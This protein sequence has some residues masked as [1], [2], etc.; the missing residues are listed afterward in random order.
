MDMILTRKISNKYGIF[1]ILTDLNQD[2]AHFCTL[3]HSYGPYLLGDVT[4]KVPIGFYTC[5]KGIHH[6]KNGWSGEMFE[7]HGVKGHSG[8]LIHPGNVEE[9]SEG[10]ILIGES[11]NENQLFNSEKSFHEFMTLQE[12]VDTFKLAVCSLTF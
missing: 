3:E 5:V 10:C 9:D 4:A 8:I 2:K 12:G 1:G 6:L 7:L 11:S